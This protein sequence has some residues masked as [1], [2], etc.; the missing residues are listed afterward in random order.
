MK[1]V[2]M[3]LARRAVQLTAIGGAVLFAAA[4]PAAANAQQPTI[5]ATGQGEVK[6][7]PRNRKI[8]V[9]IRKAVEVA[10][11]AALPLAMADARAKAA[12]M[13]AA[14]GLKLGALI[15]IADAPQ[16]GYPFGFSQQ[17]GTFGNGHFCGKVRNFK[18]VVRNGARRRVVAKGAHTACRVPP[19][20]YANVS[21]TFSAAPA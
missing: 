1:E 4:L 17:N 18:T 21:L 15:S 12:E 20:V 8:D 14:A 2:S 6:P 19:E 16:P 10:H 13:A 11:A 3:S 5:T 7:D 9:S